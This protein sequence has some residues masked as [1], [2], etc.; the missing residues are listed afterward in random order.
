MLKPQK[1][2]IKS[3]SLVF[4]AVAAAFLSAQHICLAEPALAESAA[5]HR[6]TPSV[7]GRDNETPAKMQLAN[8][9]IAA[10]D[11]LAV[12]VLEKRTNAFT[13]AQSLFATCGSRADSLL[14]CCEADLPAKK[15]TSLREHAQGFGALPLEG[16]ADLAGR[17]AKIT[18]DYWPPAHPYHGRAASV[19]MDGEA[20][21][22]TI[23]AMARANAEALLS[24]TR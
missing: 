12:Y 11:S 22:L 23:L 18:I 2:A 10:C 7:P 5:E 6:S 14:T 24:T 1:M 3:L 4:P 8:D 20:P 16:F 15:I 19:S 17:G 13:T 9:M 21:F